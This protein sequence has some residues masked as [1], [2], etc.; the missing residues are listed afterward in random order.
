MA[1]A[2]NSFKFLDTGRS[3]GVTV[4]NAVMSD[5][6]YGKHAHEELAIGVTTKGVQE[7]SCK[8][9][10]FRSLPG[11]IILFNPGEV[12]DGNPGLG[13]T[14]KYTMLY[15]NPSKF[16][17]LMGCASN[18]DLNEYRIPRTHFADPVLS[19]L[20][21][22]ISRNA[23]EINNSPLECE[24]G[25]YRI[26]SRVSKIMGIFQ[27]NNWTGVKDAELLRVRD[28]IHDNIEEDISIDDLSRVANISKYHLIRIFRSQFGLTPHQYILNHR[29]NQAR[30]VLRKGFSPTR[31]AH[32]FGFY[33]ASHMNRHFK[34]A[35]GVTPKQ[36]QSQLTA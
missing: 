29:I 17:P 1:K 2:T 24:H 20:V 16:Y 28:Y 35:Y 30:E 10:K 7:F 15:L 22:E 14:M 34:R 33:D 5:F 27:P 6:S 12:H 8:G 4:L 25:L 23:L 36:Y 26:A 32:E 19:S 18:Q 13:Q 11:N 3:R 9:S 31:V 21:L